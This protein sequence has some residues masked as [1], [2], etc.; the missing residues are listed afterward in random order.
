MIAHAHRLQALKGAS[1]LVTVLHDLDVQL[2]DVH[3]FVLEINLCSIN[4]PAHFPHL[5]K[6]AAHNI[7]NAPEH[8]DR[9]SFRKAA[10]PVAKYEDANSKT[11]RPFESSLSPDFLALFAS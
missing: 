8:R 2:F 3:G 11:H 4:M 1:T 5:V 7:R 9:S 6:Y 10:E